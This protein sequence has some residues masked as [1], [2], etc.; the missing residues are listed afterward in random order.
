[1]YDRTC[2]HAEPRLSTLPRRG[3]P[4]FIRGAWSHV[5]IDQLCLSLVSAVSYPKCSPDPR[6]RHGKRAHLGTV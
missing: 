1:M 3:G 6:Y 2:V 4:R 5:H